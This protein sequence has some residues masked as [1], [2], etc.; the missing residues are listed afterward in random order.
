MWSLKFLSGPKVGKEILLQTG[1]V[2]LGREED[3]EISID[4]PGISKKHAQITVREEDLVLEDLNSSNGTFIEGR[5]IKKEKIKEG[6]RVV[7]SDV[8]FEIRKKDSLAMASMYP[9]PQ[10]VSS[11]GPSLSEPGE[12]VI[13]RK[14]SFFENIFKSVKFYLNDVLLPGVY[15]LAEWIE[16][17][18]LIASF[19]IGFAL[20]VIILSAFPLISILRSSVEQESLNNVENI[21]I[22]LAQANRSSLQKGLQAAVNVDY[23]LRRSGVE[24]AY[25]ISAVDGRILAPSEL[26]HTYPK[27][28]FIHKARKSEQKTV[29]RISSSSVAAV[30]PI[31]FFNPETGANE[32]RAYSV[33]IYSM[34]TLFDGTKKVFSL[35]VQTFLIASVLGFI[36][37][38]FLINLIEFPIRSI[39]HQL[40][41]ALKEEQS[42]SISLNYQSQVLSDLC[43]HV[44]SALNQISLNKMIH[45]QQ[46]SK[47]SLPVNRQNEMNNLVE[48]IGFPSMAINLEDQAVAAL[49]SNFTEQLGFQ[50]ILHQPLSDISD[51][52]LREH[53]LN[54][55]EQGQVNPQ[56]I[57]FGE[58][59]LNHMSLQ[60]TCQFVMGQ[61]SPAYAIITFMSAET[62]E[63]AA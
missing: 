56:E 26:A 37:Y 57:S 27:A 51:S 60:S 43:S 61:D 3:C 8:I 21:A 52:V 34:N 5:Q 42:P 16:F 47:E 7:L 49:N 44:N 50:E 30:V 24:R 9:F 59:S 53:L 48:I 1:L 22:T 10:A 54:L 39:N 62:E 13:Q 38:F 19:M 18:F 35:V 40:G 45:S 17:R 6:D 33:V 23:A 14:N 29:E 4:S 28:S 2:T 36:L 20:I 15:R 31:S 55:I 63:G 12:N 41:K 58:I 32:P 11:T 25:I 46:D